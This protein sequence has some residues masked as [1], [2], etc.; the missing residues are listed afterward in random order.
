MLYVIS[1]N[2][3][4]AQMMLKLGGNPNAIDSIGRT[5]LHYLSLAD[6]KGEIIPWLTSK[7]TLENRFICVN[8]QT[9]SGVTPLMLACKVANP[10]IIV[11]LLKNGANPFLKDQLGNEAKDYFIVNP[12]EKNQ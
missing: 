11:E 10:R 6:Q 4:G 12:K 5:T 3:A 7:N 9:Q 8:A 1:L 2:L